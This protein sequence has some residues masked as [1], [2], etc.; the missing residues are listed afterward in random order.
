M[1]RLLIEMRA[2]NALPVDCCLGDGLNV[3]SGSESPRDC[4]VLEGVGWRFVPDCWTSLLLGGRGMA[5]T[6]KELFD[7]NTALKNHIT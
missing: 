5:T 6:E 3:A 7:F 4:A 2:K 1:L